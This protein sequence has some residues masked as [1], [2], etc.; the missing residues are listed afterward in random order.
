[1]TAEGKPGWVDGTFVVP[2]YQST[3]LRQRYVS[4]MNAVASHI[5]T[6][7]YNN[8]TYT[9]AFLGYDLRHYG[10]F[11]EGWGQGPTAPSS[12]QITD[13]YLIA[14]TDAAIAAFP[15]VQ[16]TIPMAYVAP[17]DVYNNAAGNPGTQSAY[18]VLTASNTYGRIGWRRDNMGDD[19]YNAYMTGTTASYN[20]TPL[21]PL[22]MDAW[23]VAPIGGEPLDALSNTSRCGSIQCDL[24]NEDVVFHMSYMGNGNYP[25]SASDSTALVTAVRNAS[26]E[27][28]YHLVLTGGSTTTTLQAGTSFNVTLNWQNTG[29]APVYEK[30]NVTYELRKSDGTVAW[31]GTS[32]FTPRLFLPQSTATS[33]SD[34]FMLPASVPAGTYGLYLIVRDPAGYKKPLPLAITG[35]QADGSYLLRSGI[36]L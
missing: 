1:M 35:R 15:N 26:A 18:H 21:R 19:G 34:N 20:G 12:A 36:T 10:N 3:S 29:L 2:N 16:L 24:H 17:N 27:M 33:Q 14:M 28:G 8:K 23:K 30:W 25:V 31:T 22:I 9:S 32:A 11:G 5:T 6:T 7:S 4:L 13:D